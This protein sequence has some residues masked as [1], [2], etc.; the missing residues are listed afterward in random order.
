MLNALIIGRWASCKKVVH[1]VFQYST[2]YVVLLIYICNES[3]SYARKLIATQIVNICVCTWRPEVNLRCHL[4]GAIHL[5]L[6][7]LQWF[8]VHLRGW[9]GWICLPLHPQHGDYKHVP[10]Y[11]IFGLYVF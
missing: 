1:L 3:W 6:Y 9:T 8:G 4:S 2:S 11:Q 7:S 5:V 10:S